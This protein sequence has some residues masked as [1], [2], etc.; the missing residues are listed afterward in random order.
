[1]KKLIIIITIILSCISCSDKILEISPKDRISDAAVWNDES[2]IKSYQ[3]SLYNGI[4]HGFYIHM[5][6]KYTDEA[7]NCSP[8]CCAD[9]FVNNTYTADNITTM[10]GTNLEG[11]NWCSNFFYY[12]DLGYKYIRKANVFLE[13]MAETELEFDEKAQLVAETK[14]LRAFIYFLLI[15]RFGG[16][17]I[18]DKSYNMSDSVVLK[19]NTFD[20]CVVFIEKDLSEAIPDL[21][22]SY[23]STDAN[24][25]RATQDACHALLSRTLLYAA[26]PLFN[27]TNDQSKWQKAAEAA[28]ALIGSVNYEL[29]PDYRKLFTTLSGEENKELIFTRQFSTTNFHQAPMHNLS[30]RYGSYG[31]WWASN[32]PSQNIVDDYD[33]INGE[34]AF[35][36]PGGVKTVNPASGYDPN[37]P[38]WNRDPRFDATIIH[39]STVYHGDLWEMWVASDNNT[40]GYDSYKESGDNPRTHYVWKKFMPEDDV[41]LNWQY[42]YTNPWI[43]FR[44]GEIYLN[45]AEAKFERGDEVTCRQYINLIR[46][47][48]GMPDLPATISGEDLRDR[49]YNERRIELALEGHRFF[50]VRRW[51]IAMEIENKPIEGMDIII[52]VNTGATTYTPIVLLEKTFEEKMHLLPIATDEIKKSG[53]EQNPG[54]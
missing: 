41:P 36:Y 47:R 48:A 27:T 19:R 18:L 13:K 39:D 29:H 25:G 7:Y 33:M 17:P 10:G 35:I 9:L 52:D 4:P 37:H 42:E 40:W 44:L 50:D 5:I 12:W 32:G 2:L 14:F 28:E 16:V 31:G 15:E 26:S 6:S 45:Y 46:A 20:E 53:L 51:K 23:A 8:C 43:H 30:R 38:Y 11:D 54:W 24:F 49:L 1:M 21:P 34:P 22:A 3:A